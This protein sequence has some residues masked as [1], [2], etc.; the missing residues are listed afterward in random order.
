MFF[1]RLFRKT[2]YKESTK[3][4][5]NP[6][7]GF[8][9][10]I[11]HTVGEEPN[12]SDW[13][14]YACSEERLLLLVLDIG[15]YASVSLS[16]AALEQ[17]RE[18]I[19][20]FLDHEKDLILRVVY[21]HEGKSMLRE[22]SSFAQVKEHMTTV[23]SLVREFGQ[24]IFVFQ[25]VLL[26]NW[27]EMHGSKY[28]SKHYIMELVD[29]MNR[30]FAGEIYRAVRCPYHLRW[31]YGRK[32]DYEALGRVG[33]GFYNDGLLGSNTDIGTFSLMPDEYTDWEGSWNRK[34]ELE[35]IG[36]I[37]KLVPNG[38]ETVYGDG[39]SKTISQKELFTYFQTL[40]ITYLNRL[41]DSK[42]LDAWKA[43]KVT[44]D[45]VWVYKNVYDYMEAHLG[46]RF[47]VRDCKAAN[48]GK[49]SGN[50]RVE[51]TVSLE[52][53]GFAGAYREISAVLT[54]VDSKGKHY[55]TNTGWQLQTLGSGE[56][57]KLQGII[58]LPDRKET[59][60]LYLRAFRERD[61][62]PV[63]FGNEQAGEG[64]LL[65]TLNL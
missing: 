1:G 9:P 8:Y 45:P 29:I 59:Y 31:A 34:K 25:G 60:A 39:Y 37:C 63:Y 62:V 3:V 50:H 40:H 64:V 14:Y 48:A 16:E 13:E 7:R 2:E 10:L 21:D 27:G 44:E 43:Q 55:K 11:H 18:V 42:V 47:L 26:G 65:G 46:Y 17:M 52:N 41:Y 33:I 4:R 36:S 15:N 61:N 32:Q 49:A 19:N 57:K 5:H 54:A 20:Y 56:K 53:T 38:G 30:E 35:F 51:V 23:C 12:F 28:L 58:S 22:P 6:D 24:K